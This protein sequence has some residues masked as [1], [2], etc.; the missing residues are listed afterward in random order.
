MTRILLDG[1]V[2]GATPGGGIARYFTELAAWF[3][4]HPADEE[5]FIALPD[6]APYRLEQKLGMKAL[7]RRMYGCGWAWR[8]LRPAVFH[9]TYYTHPD[10]KCP[11]VAT[12]Y[13]FVDARLPGFCPN[14]P[15]FVKRQLDSIRKADAVVAISESTKKDAAT[16]S[17][18]PEDRILVAYPG[19][20]PVFA[21]NPPSREEVGKFRAGLAGGFPYF[22]HVGNRGGY[23]NFTLLLE[24]FCV[25]ARDSDMHL[26]LSGGERRLSPEELALLIRHRMADRVHLAGQLDDG[27]L[28]L[29]YA[30]A[31]AMLSA[32]LAEGFG[33]PIIECLAC[34][35][36]VLLSAIPVYQEVAG[37]AARYADPYELD[38]WVETIRSAVRAPLGADDN[39]RTNIVEKFQTAKAGQM[40]RN[41]YRKLLAQ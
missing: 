9:S 8:L 1:R 39:A 2:Y 34:G 37:A 41:L 36:R 27:S 22:L 3:R 15:P 12:V 26:V 5:F 38:D 13:D 18:I 7:P 23:K 29:A 21:R 6:T 40:Y 10:L 24:A 31:E 19:L 17:G 16:W 4:E 14:G 30:G 11:Q 28:R 20:S 32:S 33:I 25:A 35:G